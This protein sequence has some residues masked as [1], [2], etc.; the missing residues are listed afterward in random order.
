MRIL[1]PALTTFMLLLCG[2][3]TAER[4]Y[5]PPYPYPYPY[6]LPISGYSPYYAPI[7]PGIQPA[8]QAANV[9]QSTFPVQTAVEAPE[10]IEHQQKKRVMQK[11]VGVIE[12]LLKPET[13]EE[14]KADVRIETPSPKLPDSVPE[15][16]LK[17][18]AEV[19][20]MESL[21]NKAAPNAAL[22]QTQTGPPP[23]NLKITDNTAIKNPKN[24]EVAVIQS[25]SPDS[26]RESQ[27][28]GA[29][30]QPSTDSGQALT[31]ADKPTVPV[32]PVVMELSL[33]EK[34]SQSQPLIEAAIKN[35]NFAEAYYLWRPLAEAGDP[36]A[37]YGIGWM[38]HN[39][40]GLSVDDQKAYDWWGK[41]A[42]QNYAEAI[43]SIGTLY[44]FGY[45]P[46]K[47]DNRIA[48]SYYLMA[49]VSGHEES[50]L[51]LKTRLE[52]GDKTIKPIL[53]ALLR[54][55]LYSTIS[56]DDYSATILNQML[57]KND[58]RIKPVLSQLLKYHLNRAIEGDTE[59]NTLLAQMVKN[60]DSRITNILPGLLSHY[61]DS[62][63]SGD[64]ESRQLLRTMM[65]N[66]DKRAETI[67]A[68]L[69]KNHPTIL[70]NIP[71]KVR[72]EHANTRMGPGTQHKIIKV[73]KQGDELM[74]IDQKDGWFLA[75][76]SDSDK[77]VWISA[78]LV[79]LN[80]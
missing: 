24:L 59:S 19:E 9:P 55:H 33:A 4:Y 25:V 31:I 76:L 29:N 8:I 30:I 50:R 44:Q 14:R 12:P 61:R 47:K 26:V 32:I 10:K 70:G 34:L 22:P 49:A 21:S 73:V 48:L 60:H 35:G 79:N 39:G 53:S 17:K 51:I 36:S 2:N 45:D 16:T 28:V 80:P 69:L 65:L 13:A 72:V 43:F 75:Q 38:Y 42:A 68:D 71:A 58:P 7:L 15:Q 57:L 63:I 40:Y 11:P 64:K 62:A 41:A 6:P 52:S 3:A 78:R 5:S 27:Q 46:L 74:V 23:A 77:R 1:G 66:G 54:Y 56:G 20:N 67:I 18:P 37:Q